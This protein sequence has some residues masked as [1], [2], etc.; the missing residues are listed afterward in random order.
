MMTETLKTEICDQ[1]GHAHLTNV[2]TIAAVGRHAAAQSAELT[3]SL[4]AELKNA[5]RQL[6][7][8][9]D[10]L[11][12]CPERAI[13]KMA[14]EAFL[15]DDNPDACKGGEWVKNRRYCLKEADRNWE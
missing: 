10:L 14:A 1:C 3:R 12:S 11:R 2:C 7:L 15:N 13:D 6:G 9:V 8:V 4:E 5:E